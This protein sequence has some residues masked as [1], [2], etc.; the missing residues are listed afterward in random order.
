MEHIMKNQPKS[1]ALQPCHTGEPE[2]N[3]CSVQRAPSAEPALYM[4]LFIVFFAS[5]MAFRTV[6]DINGATKTLPDMV[7]SC[8]TI[9]A[10][11]ATI[12][13]I[14]LSVM[15]VQGCKGLQFLASLIRRL[16]AAPFTREPGE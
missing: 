10:A 12:S 16:L 14:G 4:V 15:T 7:S 8:V 13:A 9:H 11:N 6:L 2:E 3:R 1:P 5:L